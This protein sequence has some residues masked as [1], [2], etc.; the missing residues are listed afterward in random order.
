[1]RNGLGAVQSVLVLGGTSEIAGAT[2]QRLVAQRTKRVILAGRD[3]DALGTVADQLRGSG[4]TAVECVTFDALQ[5][6]SH[7]AFV[8]QAFQGGD[9]DLV[10][11]T[12]GVLAEQD[13]C[14]QDSRIAVEMAQVNYVGA[15]SVLTPIAEQLRL[16]GHG[17]IVVLSSVAGERARR[18][19][20]GSSRAGLDTFAQGLADRVAGTGVTVLIVRPGLVRTSRTVGRRPSAWATTPEAVADAILDGIAAD[21]TVVWV[22]PLL[23]FVMTIA[24][25][26]PRPIVRRLS[27]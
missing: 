15:V 5:T 27:V 9:I 19:N 11:A 25:H 22:P 12:F 16:Q 26:A 3:G 6:P 21:R 14:E 4:D 7:V 20:Y 2:L 18:S 23:R 10:L 13:P 17:S 24:R 8:E 1:M